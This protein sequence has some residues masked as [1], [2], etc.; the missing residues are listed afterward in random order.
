M[1]EQIEN[2]RS[3]QAFACELTS[4]TGPYTCT[5]PQPG[6]LGILLELGSMGAG[7]AATSL[8]EVLQEPVLID[9][10]KIHK[11]PPHMLPKFYERHDEPT[12]AVYMQLANS[13]CDILLMFEI[14]EAKRIAAMMTMST[15]VEELDPAME[16]SA[17]Q[18]LANI[19]IG[20]FLSAI[21]D[22]TGVQLMPT[23]PQRIVDTFDAVIDNFLVK[24]SLVSNE[25][26]IFDTHFK[27]STESGKSILMLFPSPQL[28]ELLLTKSKEL[29]GV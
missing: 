7:H 21:S 15:S 6:E 11:I 27:R 19:I 1:K 29:M 17:I 20:S 5:P 13:E 14:S 8:S 25:A 18:E 23:T 4:D 16:E 2:N 9:I 26:L 3:T 24:Q 12:T 28:Q 10:P 22:F